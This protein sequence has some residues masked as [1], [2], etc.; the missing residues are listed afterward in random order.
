MIASLMG[1][2]VPDPGYMTRANVYT[3]SFVRRF[4]CPNPPEEEERGQALSIISFLKFSPSIVQVFKK[5]IL[6]I[7]LVTCPC[8]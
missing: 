2:R 6:P 5:P 4:S 3:L 1:G 7:T 8:R